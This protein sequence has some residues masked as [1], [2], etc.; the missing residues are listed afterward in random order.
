MPLLRP[1][2]RVVTSGIREGRV[3]AEPL[4]L[5][6]LTAMARSL[7]STLHILSILLPLIDLIPSLNYH[8]V[9]PLLL[10][11]PSSLI[12]VPYVPVRH[13]AA[14]R[15]LTHPQ[16]IPPRPSHLAAH[17]N[18]QVRSLPSNTTRHSLPPSALS[19]PPTTPV[20]S[21]LLRFNTPPPR[22]LLIGL[23]QRPVL[24]SLLALPSPPLILVALHTTPPLPLPPIL[25]LRF[26]NTPL[27]L[28]LLSQ[29]PLPM[30]PPH[31][32]L[33]Q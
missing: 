30:E 22:V 1:H 7:R 28:E 25:S 21:L 31:L 11:P 19:S 9:G 18:G 29:Q 15:P 14:P 33:L 27:R 17:F 10:L 13:P 24:G 6:F 12:Q 2:H 20:S 3:L 8:T 23:R 26:L 32:L 16:H 5:W 4:I